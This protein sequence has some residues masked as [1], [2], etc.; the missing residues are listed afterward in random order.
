MIV[1]EVN[2]INGKY[3]LRFSTEKVNSFSFCQLNIWIRDIRNG[4]LL[5][6]KKGFGFSVK[7]LDGII[8]GFIKLKLLCDK[9]LLMN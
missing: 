7:E 1:H 3:I 9:R 8:K 2:L 5:Q 4:D 6:T